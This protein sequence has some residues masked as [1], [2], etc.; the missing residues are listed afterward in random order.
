[1][2]PPLKRAARWDSVRPPMQAFASAVLTYGL[3]VAIGLQDTSWA[4]ISAL[5]VSGASIGNNVR[6]GITRMAGAICGLLIGLAGVF[7]IG[8]GFPQTVISLGL[9]VAIMG[10]I[11]GLKP[12]LKY[13]L[14]TL[15]ILILAP[16]F[17]PAETAWAKA[18]AIAIGTIVG[19]VVGM[20]VLP[21]R[22]HRRANE[23]LGHA[24]RC[25]GDLLEATID[26]LT[27]EDAPE[28]HPFHKRILDE[29]AAAQDMAGQSQFRLFHPRKH[30][31]MPS[32]VLT[33]VQRLWHTLVILD[34]VDERALPDGPRQRTYSAIQRAR[35][36]ASQFLAELGDALA[37]GRGCPSSDEARSCLQEVTS[38]L[39][40][41]R[42]DEVI[43][44]L[45]DRDAERVYAVSFGFGEI[46]R[47][48]AEISALLGFEGEHKSESV[49]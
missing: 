37:Y 12:D 3:C 10:F 30:V 11:V 16:G 2:L 25:C 22:A 7:T 48:F 6:S 17:D 32:E 23:H 35:A 4:I 19:T 20:V 14:V 29:M 34:R 33:A 27:G 28:L 38:A 15:A 46:A 45:S 1:M 41:A 40:A 44:A 24:V 43:A 39:R 8:V 26:R 21:L 31:V 49:C 47:N 18:A 5:L 42:K 36:S 9:A 13:G